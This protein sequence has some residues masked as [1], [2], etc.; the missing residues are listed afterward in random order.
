MT[1]TAETALILTHGDV[2][3]MVSAILLL[4]RLPAG[5]PIRITNG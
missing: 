4:Q 3:G 5:T 2:D 1:M